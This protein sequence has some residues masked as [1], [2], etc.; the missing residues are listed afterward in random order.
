M[1]VW[2]K[3][4]RSHSSSV[5]IKSGIDDGKI[6]FTEQRLQTLILLY[7]DHN[8][9]FSHT[10]IWVDVSICSGLFRP[11]VTWVL[12]KLCPMGPNSISISHTV[13]VFPAPQQGNFLKLPTYVNLG[14][15]GTIVSS[16]YLAWHLLLSQSRK[17]A[18]ALQ[19]FSF[20]PLYEKIWIIFTNLHILGFN[21]IER[22]AC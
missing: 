9:F 3:N 18:H 10:V 15:P 17:K 6:I 16:L 8:H 7:I 22:N 14:K 11:S 5:F 13:N 4:D 12:N 19:R 20:F 1:W 2:S 21:L